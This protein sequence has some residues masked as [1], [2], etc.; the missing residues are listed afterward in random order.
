MGQK[1]TGLRV[2][3]EEM[4]GRGLQKNGTQQVEKGIDLGLFWLLCSKE[5]GR[6]RQ[7]DAYWIVSPR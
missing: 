1:S 4:I 7:W 3:G 6:N 2:G 5:K